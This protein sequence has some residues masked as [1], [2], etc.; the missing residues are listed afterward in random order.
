MGADDDVDRPVGQAVLDRLLVLRRHQTG[1]LLDPQRQALEP[2]GETPEMLACQQGRRHHDGHLATV[3]GGHEGGPQGDFGLAEPD[4]AADQPVHHLARRQVVQDLF[5]RAELILGL[6]IRESGREL[7]VQ[8]VGRRQGLALA[9]LPRGGDAH[10]LVRH[11]PEPLLDLGLAGLPTGPAEPVETGS[12]L[13]GAVAGKDF[14]VL[15][16]HEQLVIAGIHQLQAIMG[17]P[18]GTDGLQPHI[19]ADAMVDMDDEVAGGQGGDLLQE[20]IGLPALAGRARQP[21]AENVLLGDDGEVGRL[22]AVLQRQDDRRGM[23]GSQ[24]A[25]PGKAVDRLQLPHAVLAQHRHQPVP[26]ACGVAGDQHA[27]SF[28]AFQPGMLAHRIER[29]GVR[30]GADIGEVPAPPTAAIDHPGGPRGRCERGQIPDPALG[31]APVQ[32]AAHQIE[33]AWRQRLV[34][35]GG[36][37]LGLGDQQGHPGLEE[38]VDLGQP[39]GL[40]MVGLVI[41]RHRGRRHVVQQGC[42]TVVEQRQPMLHP[43]MAPAGRYGLVERI[44]AQDGAEQPAIAGTEPG[45]A[46]GIQAKF[47]H[48]LESYTDPLPGSALRQGIEAADGFEFIAEE[49]EADGLPAPGREQI[50]DAAAHRVLARLADGLGAGIAVAREEVLQGV[51]IDRIA[52]LGGEAGARQII[53]GRNTLEDAVDGGDDDPGGGGLLAG[54]PVGQGGEHV[55]APGA[56]VRIGGDPVVGQA[57]PSREHL[58]RHLRCE[59]RDR[60]GQTGR[61]LVVGGNVQQ[62]RGAGPPGKI[63]EHAS[64]PS[65]APPSTTRPGRWSAAEDRAT[66]MDRDFGSRGTRRTAAVS[67][68]SGLS[69]PRGVVGMRFH[70]RHHRRV[71][72]HRHWLSARHPVVE[73]GIAMGDDGFELVE[74]I[75]IEPVEVTVGK[76]ADQQ[77]GLPRPTMPCPKPQPAAAHVDRLT[78]RRRRR[79][80]ESVHRCAFRSRRRRHGRGCPR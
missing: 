59:E 61:P 72:L 13:F 3:H 57:I 53:G 4:I 26:G 20:R 23:A 17:C 37:L 64:W 46:V 63:G 10:Q 62:T 28:G 14:D 67:T 70:Q 8:P 60:R 15:H 35:P 24:P 76:A 19:P 65:G 48:R 50:D 12:R 6:R 25:H 80:G 36:C 52:D 74:L 2:L 75:G 33:L 34:G 31:Q 77:I 49:V 68:A 38:V 29:A 66:A 7:V 73:I 45:D 56:H 1:E 16:R 71:Q 41:H 51:Q 78:L 5:D 30:I 79:F 69:A 21:V 54:E 40:G 11:V 58:H 44:L 9:Q 42:H 27:P 32:L 18:S 39:A 43:G 22:E 55:K 47:R